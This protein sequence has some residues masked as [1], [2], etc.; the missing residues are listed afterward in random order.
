MVASNSL[1]GTLLP[2]ESMQK[3][4]TSAVSASLLEIE[5]GILA[6]QLL[7]LLYHVTQP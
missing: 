6:Q 3:V 1:V 2:L 4:C 7:A 5:I